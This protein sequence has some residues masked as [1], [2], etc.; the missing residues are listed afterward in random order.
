MFSFAVRLMPALDSYAEG[1]NLVRNLCCYAI[2]EVRVPI[3]KSNQLDCSIYGPARAH[4]FPKSDRVM[5][6]LIPR[7][8]GEDFARSNQGNCPPDK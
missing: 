1:K 8:S 7:D 5:S 2:Q 3:A 6:Q 4:I